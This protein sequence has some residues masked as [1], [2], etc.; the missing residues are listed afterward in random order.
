MVYTEESTQKLKMEQ[1]H[2]A[3]MINLEHAFRTE[4]EEF[5]KYWDE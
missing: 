4:L 2:F 3:Q 5:N 1:K